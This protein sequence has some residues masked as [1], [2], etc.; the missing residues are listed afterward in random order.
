MKK[1]RLKP[2]L[3]LEAVEVLH[4]KGGAQTTKKGAR[5]YDRKKEK[6][7]LRRGYEK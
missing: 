3:P 1:K 5:G 6:E 7:K 4:R 2:R